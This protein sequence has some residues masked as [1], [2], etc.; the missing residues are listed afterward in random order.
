MG[1]LADSLMFALECVCY[2]CGNPLYVYETSTCQKWFS[3]S[4]FPTSPAILLTPLQDNRTSAL[5]FLFLSF[6]WETSVFARLGTQTIWRLLKGKDQSMVRVIH[7]CLQLIPIWVLA[8]STLLG[9]QFLFW[10][11]NRQLD[12]MGPHTPLPSP[13]GKCCL[14]ISSALGQRCTI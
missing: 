5:L 10:F 2:F 4:F 13:A 9:S 11:S 12:V 7:F 1:A 14:A 6:T 3:S 8:V